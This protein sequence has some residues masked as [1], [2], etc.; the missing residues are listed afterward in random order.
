MPLFN[1]F[2]SSTAKLTDKQ[3]KYLKSIA[4]L[5]GKEIG[6]TSQI[7]TNVLKNRLSAE[8]FRQLTATLL[9]LRFSATHD[10]YQVFDH[11]DN[12]VRKLLETI[13]K[14]ANY[15]IGSKPEETY[16]YVEDIANKGGTEKEP[17]P[18]KL[19]PVKVDASDKDS[20]EFKLMGKLA[21][22]PPVV[23]DT[24][25]PLYHAYMK[26]AG[27]DVHAYKLRAEFTRAF[28]INSLSRITVSGITDDQKE[29]YLDNA[30]RFDFFPLLVKE[31]NDKRK[32]YKPQ[33]LSGE[34]VDEVNALIATH[35]LES[36]K[37]STKQRI[38]QL[39]EIFN[40]FSV[41][42]DSRSRA[43]QEF[44]PV[45]THFKTMLEELSEAENEQK[46]NAVDEKVTTYLNKNDFINYTY[47]GDTPY[48]RL[49]KLGYQDEPY[50]CA[51]I[52]RMLNEGA[53]TKRSTSNYEDPKEG[54]I[55]KISKTVHLGSPPSVSD[56]VLA[57]MYN[58]SSVL[59]RAKKAFADDQAKVN[60]PRPRAQSEINSSS[61][62]SSSAD[63]ERH[64]SEPVQPKPV[65]W[66]MPTKKESDLS[67]APPVPAAVTNDLTIGQ[68][69]AT[70]TSAAAQVKPT[71]RRRKCSNTLSAS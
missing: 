20:P 46:I 24:L 50:H 66:L 31:L 37:S 57:K 69:R 14:D 43:Y 67:E 8:T 17:S 44:E 61:S 26:V 5:N 60:P 70:T 36:K 10:I 22:I 47:N 65:T 12:L 7:I 49:L 21:A 3:E 33:Q 34:I 23:I 15:P 55:A 51:L 63:A 25:M 58:N 59:A 52:T 2:S 40:S 39:Q 32:S 54:F 1:I 71:P 45:S 38:E 28:F 4:M 29:A 30:R 19:R 6:A 18:E 35:L 13:L 48:L 68:S 9:E 11:P 42:F 53:D 64:Q 16:K 56:E 41:I 62:S 27:E